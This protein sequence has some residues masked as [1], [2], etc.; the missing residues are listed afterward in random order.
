MSTHSVRAAQARRRAEEAA[1]RAAGLRQRRLSGNPTSPVTLRVDL[2][3]ARIRA[4][5]AMEH[6]LDALEASAQAH[7]RTARCYQDRMEHDHQGSRED[8]ARKAAQHREDASAD[9]RR[10]KG[11]QPL[12]DSLLLNH[13]VAYS[14]RAL[15]DLISTEFGVADKA[16]QQ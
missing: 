8:F 11:I 10:A 7:D 14:R 15:R 1:I 16:D 5:D 9:R 4:I 6:L 13:E 3:A 12:L 2:G